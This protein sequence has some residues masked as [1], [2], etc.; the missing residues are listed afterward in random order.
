MAT[1]AILTPYAAEFPSSNFP[2]L[3]LSNRRPVLAFD[4]GGSDEGTRVYELGLQYV[5]DTTNTYGLQIRAQ[6]ARSTAW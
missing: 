4:L 1:R 5:Y 6:N 3:T 2:Q